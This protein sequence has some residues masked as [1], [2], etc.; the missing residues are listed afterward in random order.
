MIPNLDQNQVPHEGSKEVA[1]LLL[2]A[3]EAH[4]HLD[5]QFKDI[6]LLTLQFLE[7]KSKSN[8]WDKTANKRELYQL[9]TLLPSLNLRVLE[10]EARLITL[11][12]RVLELDPFCKA[13]INRLADLY[14][15][16]FC[17]AED[18][19]DRF[20]QKRYLTLLA[21]VDNGRYADLIEGTATLQLKTKPSGATI[22][23]IPL[24][25]QDGRMVPKAEQVL[26]KSPLTPIDIPPGSY[27][28]ELTLKGYATVKRPFYVSRGMDL[29]LMVHLFSRRQVGPQFIH[30]AA[31][32]FWM[33][34][35][36]HAP[37]AGPK[38]APFL[39][40]FAISRYPVTVGEYQLFLDDLATQN[41]GLALRYSPQGGFQDWSQ[42]AR[43]PITG[44][45]FSAAVAYC[46]WFSQRTGILHRLPT[47]EEWEKSARGVDG[48]IYPWGNHF[49]PSFCLMRRSLQD[50]PHLEPIGV[51][52]FDES[53]YGVR[54]LAGGVSEWTQSYYDGHKQLAVI[55]GGSFQDSEDATRTAYRQG[56]SKEGRPYIGFRLVRPLP[57]GGGDRS[58]PA[59]IPS[60]SPDSIA[61]EAGLFN[62]AQGRFKS[63]HERLLF[64][65]RRLATLENPLILLPKLLIEALTITRSDKGVLLELEGNRF[66]ILEA[67]YANQKKIDRTDLRLDDSIVLSALRQERPITLNE[68][69]PILALPLPNQHCCLVL[70]RK[71]Q[72]LPFPQE[73]L[74]H[75]QAVADTIALALRLAGQA[76]QQALSPC[77]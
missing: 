46:K 64:L 13:A 74:L 39:D 57:Q 77:F 66:A 38:T 53:I 62:H 1:A 4:Q 72:S 28:L 42:D 52:E 41:P 31:G 47:E 61:T 14:W 9:Q 50:G 71:F 68:P 29:Q 70:M 22:K 76:S 63:S 3:Y 10:H 54:D 7:L 11:Y 49:D 18:Q 43:L 17:R 59:P 33:G 26:G 25:E 32:R 27:Q 19:G 36:G 45:S 55:R 2:Q 51:F 20:A 8:P 65:S 12:H 73:S 69:V 75:A 35:D 23:L 16:L 6:D 58:M 67:R 40:N 44:I 15:N 30:I 21:A 37:G 60:S 24:A 34:G 48:R 5:Q 56:M